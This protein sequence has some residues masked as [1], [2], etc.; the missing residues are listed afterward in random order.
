MSKKKIIKDLD[1]GQ[2]FLSLDELYISWYLEEL[3]VTGYVAKW[4]YE[5]KTFLLG[6]GDLLIRRVEYKQ[7]QTKVSK[8]ESFPM[9]LGKHNYTPDFMVRFTDKAEDIFF[10]NFTN[11][12]TQGIPFKLYKNFTSII[13][14]KF[15]S[16]KF[17]GS[18]GKTNLSRKWM[19]DKLDKYVEEIKYKELFYSSFTP[20]RF[21]TKDGS[22]M[23]LQHTFTMQNL[24]DYVKTRKYI[25]KKYLTLKNKWDNEN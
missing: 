16:G 20:K 10:N 13:E 12:K 8:K 21:Q 24:D 2:I 19:L 5:P 6:E 1:T 9:L 22:R 11:V 15:E 14:V 3:R 18:K 7:L 23:K 4:A 25:N 17:Q